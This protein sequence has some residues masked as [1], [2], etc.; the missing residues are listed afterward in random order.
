[1][2]ADETIE[3]NWKTVSVDD[4]TEP[5]TVAE[6]IEKNWKLFSIMLPHPVRITKFGNNREKLKE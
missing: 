5:T 4:D 6:T 2:L 1:M 3:K